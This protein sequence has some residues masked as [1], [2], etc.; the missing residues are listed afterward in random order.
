MKD[1]ILYNNENIEIV[2][3]SYRE[4][5][6]NIKTFQLINNETITLLEAIAQGV[7]YL[8]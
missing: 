2:N 4:K 8:K 3:C 1:G 6:L 7:I 5:K